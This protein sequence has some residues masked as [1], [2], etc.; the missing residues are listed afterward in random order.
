MRLF[1]QYIQ[2]LL[3]LLVL[4]ISI[5]SFGQAT[6]TVVTGTYRGL[7][8]L[9]PSGGSGITMQVTGGGN[10][11]ILRGGLPQVYQNQYSGTINP[12]SVPGSTVNGFS[13]FIGGNQYRS[14][15][16]D[17]TGFT[18]SSLAASNIVSHTVTTVPNTASGVQSV[19]INYRIVRSTRNYDFSIT[20]SW[21]PSTMDKFFMDVSFTIPSG[22]PAGELIK[23]ATGWDTMLGASDYGPSM[24]IGVAPYIKMGTFST[25]SSDYQMFEYISG[26]PWSGYYAGYYGNMN[27]SSALSDG[28]FAST[29]DPT[30][31]DSGIGISLNFGSTPGTFTS[32]SAVLF[33]CTA[34]RVNPRF[35]T[36][37]ATA[38]TY[39]ITGTCATPADLASNYLATGY[40][41]AVTHPQTLIFYDSNYTEI[42]RRTINSSG[43]V[44]GLPVLVQT[45]TYY[46]VYIDEVNNCTSPTTTV[47]VTQPTNCPCYKPPTVLSGGV[48][49][50]AAISTISGRNSSTPTWPTTYR[51]ADMVVESRARGFVL[52]RL[53]QV[54]IDA[55]PVA[56][57]VE[58]MV[59]YNLTMHKMNIYV[60][61]GADKGWKVFETP[62][63]L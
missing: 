11:Q 37:S 36:M 16:L 15:G 51:G 35:G 58:G 49:P 6:S 14:G 44:Q 2:L 5:K 13:I 57:L 26:V 61:N 23:F 43:V 62:S 22:H 24:K 7:T 60:I 12:F 53:T 8:T 40:S 28:V 21:N 30:S 20:Y 33:S 1:K 52:N 41:T 42:T 63:C 54:Q 10:L 56:N 31:Q 19:K 17:G 48:H 27:G 47:T 32:S 50:I 34:P 38:T 59:V 9:N 39:T 46:V 3:C 45:G 29:F 25:S 55:I 4:T 18:D